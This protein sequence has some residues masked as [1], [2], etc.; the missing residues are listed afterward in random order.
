MIAVIDTLKKFYDKQNTQK[1]IVLFILITVFTTLSTLYDIKTG[2]P[3]TW[4]QNPF[5]W[6]LNILIAIYSVQFL[7][8]C[9][10][11]PENA[12][13]PF[14]SKL[15]IKAIPGQIILSIIWTLYLF[16][17]CILA[18]V[19]YVTTNDLILPIIMAVLVIGLIPYINYSYIRFAQ[20]FS[21]KNTFSIITLIKDFKNEIKSTMLVYLQY[22]IAFALLFAGYILLYFIASLVGIAEII[23]VAENY[24][25]FDFVISAFFEYCLNLLIFFM[26]PYALFKI[27]IISQQQPEERIEN[28]DIEEK[29]ENS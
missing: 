7:H 21:L 6:T 18:L 14:W 19:W 3:D 24:Y 28:N 26:F 16:I 22:I 17:I 25:L 29:N 10:K 23:P 9:F 4:K 11:N 2:Q 13:L 20:Y 27:F 12:I 5:D 8:D 15:E 1:H